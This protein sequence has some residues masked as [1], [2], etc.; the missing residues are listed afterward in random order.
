MART[1]SYWPPPVFIAHWADGSTTRAAFWSQAG[2]PLDLARGYRLAQHYKRPYDG[3]TER[4]P[5]RAESAWR[6]CGEPPVLAACEV[7]HDG[8]TVTVAPKDINRP[9][10]AVPKRSI[11]AV[12]RDLLRAI[13]QDLEPCEYAELIKE[14][15]GLL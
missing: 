12:L 3:P 2:K 1:Q 11:K 8:V 6:K 10:V 5:T 15:Q 4:E 9:L 7:E 13:D 14:A